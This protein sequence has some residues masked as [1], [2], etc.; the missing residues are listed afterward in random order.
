LLEFLSVLAAISRL[1]RK[2]K[3]RDIYAYLTAI[4][5]RRKTWA[6]IKD[7]DEDKARSI[8]KQIREKRLIDL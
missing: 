6:V 5:K 3:V 1:K 2:K 4:W 8:M 7:E